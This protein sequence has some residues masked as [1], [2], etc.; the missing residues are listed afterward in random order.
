[1]VERISSVASP[2]ANVSLRDFGSHIRAA[3]FSPNGQSILLASNRSVHI[4]RSAGPLV[5]EEDTGSNTIPLDN[6]QASS[7]DGRHTA[8]LDSNGLLR[9]AFR[10]S[11]EQV[12]ALN[13]EGERG[14]RDFAFSPRADVIA[15]AYSDGNVGLWD[16]QV[17]NEIVVHA[18]EQPLTAIVFSADETRL[19]IGDGDGVVTVLNVTN[20]R[21]IKRFDNGV[22]AINGIA[23]SND[24]TLLRVSD[25][26][27]S[28]AWD[29]RRLTQPVSVLAETAC[30]ALLLPVDRRFSDSEIDADPLIDLAFTRGRRDRDVCEGVRGAA[31]LAKSASPSPPS[32]EFRITKPLE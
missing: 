17:N 15:V 5:N 26:S 28:K 13:P 14:V 21:I 20:R 19:F 10:A 11:G 23:L 25:G 24:G 7:F 31:P 6:G 27:S 16:Y 12:A 1:M 3:S 8:A 32:R 2:I 9:V 22:A 4:Q 30:S 29:V 18:S